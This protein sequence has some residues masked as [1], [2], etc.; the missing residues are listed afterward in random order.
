MT[1]QAGLEIFMP[2]LNEQVPKDASQ[3]I[4]VQ[5]FKDRSR[6]VPLDVSVK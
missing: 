6:F 3:S 1:A 4:T 5:L 2:D